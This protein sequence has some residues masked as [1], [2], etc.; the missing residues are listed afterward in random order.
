MKKKKIL[1]AGLAAIAAAATI[2]GTWAVWT[3]TEVAH[4]EFMT[5]NYC[6][7]LQETFTPPTEWLPGEETEKAVWVNNENGE[8][9]VIAKITMSQKWKRLEDI[10]VNVATQPEAEVWEVVATPGELPIQFRQDAMNTEEFASILN[11]NKDAVVVLAEGRP[12]VDSGLRLDL[13]EVGSLKEAQGK[14]LLE[15]EDPLE[16]GNYTFYYIGQIPAGENSPVLLDSVTLNPLLENT[17]VETHTYYVED[18]NEPSG[19]RKVVEHTYNS[20]GY[21]SSEYTLTITMQTVQ[22]TPDAVDS[23]LGSTTTI[24]RYLKDEV[25]KDIVVDAS[26]EEKT[27]YFAEV[28]G[29]LGYRPMDQVSADGRETGNWFMRFT[30]MVPGGTYRDTLNIHNGSRK[31]YHLYMTIK[32]REEQTEKQKELLEKIT[33]E[34]VYTPTGEVLYKGKATGYP[35][36]DASGKY[37]DMQGV[38]YLGRYY[39]G[40]AGQIQVKLQL[41]PSIGFE[42]D[43]VTGKEYYYF[44]DVLTKIDW[45]FMVT[46][47][48]KPGGGGSSGG[49]GGGSKGGGPGPGSSDGEVLSIE[50]EL[51]PLGVLPTTGDNM[52]IIPVIVTAVVSMLLMLLFAKLGFGK[53]K[54]TE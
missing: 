37:V 7:D 45:E 12:G 10:K 40:D 47:I 22:A 53:S 28:N 4:N 44:S 21:D 49:G 38:V 6:T 43:P 48:T 14:W 9:P 29:E 16:V 8:V 54:K 26:A 34:V 25:A 1:I 46:E 13:P 32:P 24:T 51:I 42:K 39:R 27:L 3:Q 15:T 50:D 31:D 35:Y 20:N 11:L 5:A 41:D 18:A 17:V 33:M 36:S 30:N 23:V 2:G 19:Y 52:P